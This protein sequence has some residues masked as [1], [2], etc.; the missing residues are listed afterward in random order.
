MTP[1]WEKIIK[2]ENREEWL[3]DGGE[4]QW[5]NAFLTGQPHSDEPDPRRAPVELN[6]MDMAPER[7]WEQEFLHRRQGTGAKPAIDAPAHRESASDRRSTTVSGDQARGGTRPVEKPLDAG[8]ESTEPIGLRPR[9]G[10]RFT[11]AEALP[12]V[13]A[14]MRNSLESIWTSM[15]L[16]TRRDPHTFLFCGATRQEGT[17]FVSFHLALYLAIEHGLRT[18]YLD[19]DTECRNHPFLPK[20]LSARPG[21]TSYFLDNRGLATLLVPTQFRNL[22]LLPAGGQDNR[23]KISSM[24]FEKSLLRGLF[25]FARRQFDVVIC[26]GR[27]IVLQPGIIGFAKEVD[28]VVMVCR[29]GVSRYEVTQLGVE[30]LRGNGVG[31]IGIVLND[32]RYPIPA[33][34]YKKL[35]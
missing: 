20:E 16:D 12:K 32:R 26:D 21:L 29:Y 5:E 22:S 3:V 28:Q 14:M 27:P 31:N 30:K 23:I 17:T 15:V 4:A 18:L 35:K 8:V 1:L 9:L 13:L 10:S 7:N 11:E 2:R 19:T 24:I 25:E 34:I 33:R 6:A